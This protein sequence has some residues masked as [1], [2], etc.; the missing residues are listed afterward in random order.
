M[1]FPSLQ[2]ATACGMELVKKKIAMGGCVRVELQELND[3]WESSHV[4]FIDET[5]VCNDF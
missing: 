4:Y 1:E 3:A 5:G 2:S